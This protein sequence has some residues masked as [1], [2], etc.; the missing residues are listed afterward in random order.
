LPAESALAVR[1]LI[2]QW[3]NQR[4]E[5][6]QRKGERHVGQVEAEAEKLQ[7]ELMLPSDGERQLII[8]AA[9]RTEITAQAIAAPIAK[10]GWRLTKPLA[11]SVA[12]GGD[13]DACYGREWLYWAALG[14]SSYS[15]RT[16]RAHS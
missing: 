16:P 11:R 4:V 1:N 3:L 10:S 6:Y 8:A 2:R 9:I 13:A 12:D 5:F 15:A 14:G 7:A